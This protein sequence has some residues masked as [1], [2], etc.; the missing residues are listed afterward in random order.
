MEDLTREILRL[1]EERFQQNG[2]LD[3]FDARNITRFSSI[4]NNWIEFCRENS[5][6]IARLL[7]SGDTSRPLVRF[8]TEGMI[9]SIAAYNQF[10]EV[11]P[12][13]RGRLAC[14][15]E[16]LVETARYLLSG[17]TTSRTPGRDTETMLADHFV[18]LRTFME[19]I[20]DSEFLRTSGPVPCHQYGVALQ[21]KNLGIATGF[22]SEPILDL[23]CG[24]DGNL[25][26]FLRRRGFD[27]F[28]IDRFAEWSD[29]LTGADWLRVPACGG[30]WGTII[31]HMSFSNHFMH[32]HLRR[33]GRF[34]EYA[35]AYMRL[36]ASLRPGGVF[37]Y[38]PSLPFIERALPR[39]RFEV[40]R[41]EVTRAKPSGAGRGLE[42]F[43]LNTCATS[44]RRLA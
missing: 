26:R 20:G 12:P 21:M 43:D 32:H 7:G 34:E 9:R 10:V 4:P 6:S 42:G 44:V 37:F 25:V 29:Y 19:T 3:I 14:L 18:S 2:H 27:A 35:R 23:G 24:R 31:S 1:A 38:A 13:E 41:S 15:Y 30:R 17:G 40:A 16:N 8:M 22:L 28:G 5:V 36:L 11:T 39:D 33:D